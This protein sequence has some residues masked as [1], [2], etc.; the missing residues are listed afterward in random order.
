M[1][2][3][4]KQIRDNINSCENEAQTKDGLIVPLLKCLGYEIGNLSIIRPEF[5]ADIGNK[6][7]E[8]VD[9]AVMD[10]N[11]K[12]L[13]FIECKHKNEN[14]SKHRLQLKEYFEKKTPD[15]KFGILT[16]GLNYEFYTS[17]QIENKMDD[18]P[19]FKF[20][21]AN[22]DQKTRDFFAKIEYKN[23]ISNIEKIKE[24]AKEELNITKVKKLLMSDIEKP[25]D[26]FVGYFIDKIDGNRKTGN[27]I[28]EFRGYIKKAFE[29]LKIDDKKENISKPQIAQNQSNDTKPAIETTEREL[30]FYALLHAILITLDID[31]E[32]DISFRDTISY[33]GIF[34]KKKKFIE[35]YDNSKSTYIKLKPSDKKIEIE[36]LKDIFDHTSEIA[37]A[38]NE[39]KK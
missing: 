4:L 11:G 38:L 16:N 26:E 30:K 17:T 36:N 18:E 34:Y 28:D 15:V 6:K 39:L 29:N 21:I 13:I 2:E 22:I 19:F 3:V 14:L 27:K 23:I 7:G 35:F 37:E 24:F 10:T 31:A 12:P 32:E 33:F 8:K 1:E 25:S 20:S 9:Y 5:D